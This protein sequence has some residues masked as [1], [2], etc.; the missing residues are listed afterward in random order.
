MQV[1]IRRLDALSAA[2]S[3]KAYSVHQCMETK[4]TYHN[5]VRPRESSYMFLSVEGCVDAQFD[6]YVRKV[7]CWS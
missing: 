3:H 7:I 5:Y 1:L 6:M 2:I 4:A